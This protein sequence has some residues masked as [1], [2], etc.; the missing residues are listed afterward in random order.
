M[1]CEVNTAHKDIETKF[2]HPICSSRSYTWPIRHD[3]CW[4]PIKNI[5][6]LLKTPFLTTGIVRQYYLH[7]DDKQY[8]ILTKFYMIS[9]NTVTNSMF[10]CQIKSP[11]AQILLKQKIKV[12]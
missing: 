2:M 12:S 3:I 8:S 1:A 11:E 4:V 9:I 6:F 10:L 7:N 5:L